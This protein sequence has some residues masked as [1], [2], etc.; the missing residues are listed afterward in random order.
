MISPWLVALA[1]FGPVAVTLSVWGVGALAGHKTTINSMLTT[2]VAGM[3]MVDFSFLPS[4][5]GQALL[6]GFAVAT[7]ISNT[8]LTSRTT[9]T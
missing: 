7:L 6:P 2:V 5:I 4:E 1:F 8:L 3:E 9:E